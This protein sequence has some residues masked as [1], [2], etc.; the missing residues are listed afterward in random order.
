VIAS[1][2]QYRGPRTSLVME[3]QS[4]VVGA[5]LADVPDPTNP[6]GP[7]HRGA[8]VRI[9]LATLGTASAHSQLLAGRL[10]STPRFSHGSVCPMAHPSSDMVTSRSASPTA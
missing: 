6:S 3:R 10:W 9:Y 4:F 5:P 7:S 1:V 2:P 8:R